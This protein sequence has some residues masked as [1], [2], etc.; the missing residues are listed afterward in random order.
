MVLLKVAIYSL[1]ANKLRSFLAVLGVIIGVGAVI[2]ML[3]IAAG[4]KSQV[5]ST[6]SAMGTNLLVVRPAQRGSGGVM[7]GTQQNLTV[8]DAQAILA[9][10]PNVQ[11]VAPVVQGRG[12]L[13]YFDKNTG[14]SVVGAS[15]TYIP[16]RNFVIERGRLF[17]DDEEERLA[18]V[19]ILGPV[20]AQN[21][22]GDEDPVG[23]TIKLNGISFQVIGV[24]KAK[25][26]QGWFNPDDSAVVPFTIA[27]RQLFGMDYL[28]EIDIQCVP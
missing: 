26:D 3:A 21:L 15:V 19:V 1:F 23:A 16:L 4:A 24:T 17:T 9:E 20:T 27:M 18:K 5:L 22:M 14:T 2:A 10:V 28:R 25:G 13:K 8:E 7:T 12:Q 6:I 11:R